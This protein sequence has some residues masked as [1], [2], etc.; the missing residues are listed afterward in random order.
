MTNASGS[1]NLSDFY[2]DAKWQRCTVHFYR[3]VF[4]IVPKGK[5][6][7]V[8]AM[9][10]A[11]HAQESREQ[12]PVK[13]DYVRKKFLL[14]YKVPSGF[15]RIQIH[16]KDGERSEDDL[17]PIRVDCPS[18]EPVLDDDNEQGSEECS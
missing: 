4:S 17:L 11:I 15:L 14:Y 7:E 16:R 10:K 8:A 1:W 6:R 12:A 9:L 18:V 5:V 13:A 3:N 2:P